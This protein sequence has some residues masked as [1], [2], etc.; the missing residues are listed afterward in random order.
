MFYRERRE[1]PLIENA[2]VSPPK[3]LLT[4]VVLLYPFYSQDFII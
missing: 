4:K 1:I 3:R 2:V